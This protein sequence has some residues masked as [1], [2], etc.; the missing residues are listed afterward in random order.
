MKKFPDADFLLYAEPAK[1][2][3]HDYAENLPIIDYH[4]HLSPQQ[5]AEN[6]QFENLTELWLN[7]DHYKWRAMRMNG[8]HESFITGGKSDWEKFLKWAETVPY[9]LRNPLY[10]WSH[11]ELQRYFQTEK[12]LD[13]D[14]AKEIY[15]H[16]NRL[17]QTPEYRVQGLLNKMNVEIICTTDDPADSLEYHQQIRMQN[18]SLRVFPTF[19]PDRA[20]AIGDS[21]TFK[22]YLEKLGGSANIS[23]STYKHFVDALRNRHDFFHNSGCRLSDHGLEQFYET[24]WTESEIKNIFE[25]VNGGKD[26]NSE[27]K[28]KFQSAL[29]YQ[30]AEWDYE[31][32]WVQQYHLGAL[33]NN[34]SRMLADLG[35]DTGWDSIGD[36]RQAK[37]LSAFL[38][39]LDINNRLARTILYNNNPAD[40]EM[41][42][43]MI[44]NF[45]DGSVP[46]KIQWGSA[47]WF[48]D[49]KEGM[50]RQLNALSNMG[51]IS[52]FV[53]MITD[54]RSFLSFPR[55]EYFRRILCGLFGEEMERGE[56][57]Q[58]TT[59]TGKLIRDICYFNALHYF[60]W[61]KR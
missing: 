43:A 14:S 24:E 31:K 32:K 59:W 44:G 46:G 47:W 7:G 13:G 37:A 12:I 29:L 50:T 49:Q 19:R 38:N 51:L 34:N 8:V 45:N 54:S 41:M 23:I 21:S 9:T 39:S 30:L 20:L 57:P 52:R 5:I 10:H 28:E 35:Q 3:F 25:K 27:E 18:R 2:L 48:L 60:D 33:R 61:S 53:G 11:L 26:P 42:A 56:L 6:H 22:C 15:D 16:C 40:N 17:L 58:D 36:F 1:R 4:C 55:H